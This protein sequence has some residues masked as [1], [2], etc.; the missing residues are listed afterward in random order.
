MY[1]EIQATLENF[2]SRN[3]SPEDPV[4]EELNRVT[5][6]KVLNPRMI[7]G[8]LQG[9][10]LSFVSQMIH[11]KKVLEIGTFTGYSAICLAKGL[12]PD[13]LLHTIEQNDELKK[14][15]EHYFRKAGLDK[16][17][18]L[19]NG[20]AL[21]IIEKLNEKF[22]LV[23][24]DGEK[25][26]YP[27]YLEKVLL[28]LNKG[29]FILADNIFWNGK[30]INPDCEKDPSTMGILNFCELVRENQELENIIIPQR[31]GLM[32]IR[33]KTDNEINDV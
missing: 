20:D 9:K 32:L 28:K 30:V 10:L 21:Q 22:D 4:L 8:H 14:L 24:I 3:T 1:S 26:E 13:G 11:P 31:D 19:H 12:H 25:S 6:Q 5:H 29:G 27:Q 23:Y 2:I 18:V 16:Q 15:A 33:K 17:I 7:S